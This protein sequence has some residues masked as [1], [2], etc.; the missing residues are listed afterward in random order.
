MIEVIQTWSNNSCFVVDELINLSL[1]QSRFFILGLL[2][3]SWCN[4]S[5]L[6]RV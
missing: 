6:E 4:S 1:T 3:V 2:M 5:Q